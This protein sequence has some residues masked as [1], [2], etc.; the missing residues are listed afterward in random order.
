MIY[1]K[2]E[3]LGKYFSISGLDEVLKG[4]FQKGRFDIEEKSFGIGLEYET[5]SRENCLWEAHRKYVDIHLVLSGEE[6]ID[7]TDIGKMNSSK[8]YDDKGDYELF[9][10]DGDHL[11][12]LTKGYFL[13]LD[14]C[15]VH[16]TSIKID[17]EVA[18]TKYVLKYEI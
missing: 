6:M 18:L 11:I 15:D 5:K 10:G 17:N 1:D 12:K 3:N 7:I 13:A 14:P 4:D 8:E 16:R 9:T 2:I